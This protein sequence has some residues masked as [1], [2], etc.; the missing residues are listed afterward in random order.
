[1]STIFLFFVCD[2]VLVFSM[3]G[4]LNVPCFSLWFQIVLR[5][6]DWKKIFS[7]FEEKGQPEPLSPFLKSREIEF[8]FSILV[9]HP[10]SLER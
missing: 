8:F 10:F 6:Y 4:W 3:C 2:V 5:R 1:M 9:M 7:H